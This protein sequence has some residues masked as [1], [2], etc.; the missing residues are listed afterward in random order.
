MRPGLLFSA[1]C[2]ILP[3]PAKL[4]DPPPVT[5]AGPVGRQGRI[6]L[7]GFAFFYQTQARFAAGFGLAIEGLRHRCWTAHLADSEYIDLETAGVVFDDQPVARVDVARRL[8]AEAIRLNAAQIAGA[9]SHGARLEEP[10]RPEPFV[11]ANGVHPPYP[12]R[13]EISRAK[14]ILSGIA[15]SFQG[16]A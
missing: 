2:V 6:L 15:A 10:R 8:G 9:R 1:R 14:A 3:A 7:H 4:N 12:T 11:D 13:G 16:G 5:L